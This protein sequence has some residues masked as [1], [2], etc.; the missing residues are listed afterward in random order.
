M[1]LSS[2]REPQLLLRACSADDRAQSHPF[3]LHSKRTDRP[4]LFGQRGDTVPSRKLAARLQR[5]L[6]HQLRCKRQAGIRSDHSCTE[7]FTPA[8]LADGIE[9]GLYAPRSTFVGTS[10]GSEE[11]TADVRMASRLSSSV[12]CERAAPTTRASGPRPALLDRPPLLPST[13]DH[14][15]SCGSPR[16]S[17]AG[18]VPDGASR[19]SIAP[20]HAVATEPTQRRIEAVGVHVAGKTILTR[21]RHFRKA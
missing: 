11:P 15:H 4:L 13:V 6:C 8:R 10:P 1:K 2:A 21:N 18:R 7:R 12:R 16:S 9:E 5:I 17:F 3:N 19:L 14:P 20:W